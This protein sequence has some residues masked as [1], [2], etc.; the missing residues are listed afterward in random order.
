MVTKVTEKSGLSDRVR[1]EKEELL[2][3]TPRVDIE[4]VKFLL[5]AYEETEGQPAVIRRARFFDKLCSQKIIFIF[6]IV[7]LAAPYL[8]NIR[9]EFGASLTWSGF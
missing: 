1:R 4:R 9:L 8:S 3:A 5:E 2:S 7:C 6:L